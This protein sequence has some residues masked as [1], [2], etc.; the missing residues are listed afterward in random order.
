MSI[1]TKT[2]D[3]G[4]TSL[5][6]GKRV[7][8]CCQRIEA[9]GTID[10]LN[11]HIGLLR[12]MIQKTNSSA[13]ESQR[14]DQFLLKTQNSLFVIGSILAGVEMADVTKYEATFIETEI[15]HLNQ[16]LPPLHA[17]VIPSGCESACQAHICRTVCRRAERM[18]FK[19]RECEDTPSPDQGTIFEAL[20]RYVNRL[21]D[22]LFILARHLN[23]S[24]NVSEEVWQQ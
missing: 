1:Y 18:I 7:S 8:K 9:Y 5:A 13:T 24:N 12:A 11:S 23:I 4:T 16:L 15:D 2:G 20:V 6:T 21:S 3:K 14:A 22:Y 17:F 19:I 10:E